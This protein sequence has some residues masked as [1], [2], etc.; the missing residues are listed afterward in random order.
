MATQGGRSVPSPNWR[1]EGTTHGPQS[2]AKGRPLNHVRVLSIR[3]GSEPVDMTVWN[4]LPILAG[5]L[6]GGFMQHVLVA[7]DVFIICDEDGQRKYDV[8]N[9]TIHLE[10]IFGPALLVRQSNNEF[11]SITDYDIEHFKL[12]MVR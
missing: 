7:D 1:V 2:A 11:I 6:D 4:T 9:F 10:R 12:L 3:P 8:P 5:L